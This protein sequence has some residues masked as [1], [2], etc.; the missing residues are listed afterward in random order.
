LKYLP[1][2]EAK[3]LVQK[4]G[5][6]NYREWYEYCKS[7]KKREDIPTNP[8]KVYRKEWKGMGDWLGTG[9]I[10]NRHKEYRGFSEAR[11][12]VRQLNLKSQTEWR[13]YCKSGKKPADIPGNPART[14]GSLWKGFGDWLGTGRTR[15]FRS[16]EDARKFVHQLNLKSQIDWK[17][18]CTSGDIPSDIP[19]H[20]P[21]PYRKYW[22]GWG[23]FLGTGYVAVFQREYWPFDQAREYV[24]KLRIK[25]LKEW[26]KY[27]KSKE[28]P[29]G[30]PASPN[31]VYKKYWKQEGKG[32]GYWLGTNIIATHNRKHPPFD[33]ARKFVHSLKLKTREDWN[34]YCKSGN[35]PSEISSS[36]WQT[37]KKYWKGLGDWLG[38]NRIAN[39]YKTYLP[40]EQA[41]DFVRKLELSAGDW[42]DYCKSG[43]LPED[44]PKTPSHVYKNDWIV[45]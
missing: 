43:K 20:P 30:I 16:F 6:K 18:Y 15:D 40:F 24:S 31:V 21:G 9:R 37:Y 10:A 23:D 13:D 41:R 2:N 12:F 3:S 33:E 28:K 4:L 39:Q 38:T 34:N 35:K 45:N 36:P 7:G 1:F 29:K 11:E 19:L 17:E 42:D 27:A 5:L 44:V 14:Y 32:W 25:N 22:K 26:R 8:M